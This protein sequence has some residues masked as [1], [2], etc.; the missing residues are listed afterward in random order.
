M[1][2]KHVGKKI[3]GGV[4]KLLLSEWFKRWN[5]VSLVEILDALRYDIVETAHRGARGQFS[6]MGLLDMLGCTAFLCSLVLFSAA[7]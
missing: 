1:V 7:L 5:E 4:S 2:L 6:A 3:C